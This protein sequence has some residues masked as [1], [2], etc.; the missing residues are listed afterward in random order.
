MKAL[1][2]NLC[3]GY[4]LSGLL[5]A[6]TVGAA[7]VYRY[8]GPNGVV[9]YTDKPPTQGAKPV[10]LPPIQV[11]GPTPRP[12]PSG[13]VN[14]L[15]ELDPPL[16]EL[17]IASPVPEQTFRGDDRRL[18]V[19]VQ[20]NRPLPEGYGLL[21]MLDGSPQNRT[22][23]RALDY[24]LEG[25][26]RGEHLVSVAAVDNRGREVARSAPVIV[27]MKPPTVQLTRDR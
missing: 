6:T 25:V 13:T 24:V 2:V 26:E 10:E 8:V 23:T 22:A 12:T 5:A 16:V 14:A 18:S 7:E 15:P 21:Y 1:F 17:S 27:H 9:H 3:V 19:R 20:T 11:V 4:L